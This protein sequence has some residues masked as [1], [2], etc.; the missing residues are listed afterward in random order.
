MV[1]T[2]EGY[3]RWAEALRLRTRSGARDRALMER[4]S[5]GSRL[6]LCLA[7]RLFFDRGTLL[8][9]D[10]LAASNPAQIPGL[11][12]DPRVE[13]YRAPAWRYP[14]VASAL[15]RGG[16]RFSDEVRAQTDAVGPWR[17]VSIRTYQREA[18]RA[19]NAAGRRGVVVL[20]TGSGKTRVAIA[21]MA[22]MGVPTLC[23][24][25]TRVLV[26][27]WC[28]EIGAHQG[29]PI[30]RYGDGK[31]DLAPVTVSTYAS[32]LRHMHELGNRFDLLVV[33]EAHHFGS[34]THDE[35]L[36]MC[37]APARLGLTATPV[38]EPG[39][40]RRVGDLI[41][42]TVYELAIG[43]LAGTFL[44]EFDV[45]TIGV[46]LSPD[47]RE[48]YDRRVAIYRAARVLFFRG[49]PDGTWGEFARAAARTA[50]GRAALSAWR[51]ARRLVSF[52]D[53]K[54]RAV[55]ELLARHRDA[56]VLVFVSDNVAA[57][58]IAAEH[59][60]MPLTCDIGRGERDE[61]LERFRKGELRALVSARVLNEG[62][63]VPAAE[64]AIVVGGS[65]GAREHVQRI[66]RLLRPVPG[67]RAVVYELVTRDTAEVIQV[68]KRRR[69]LAAR[70][71]AGLP[72]PG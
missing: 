6:A 5:P 41:G 39:A 70:R 14:E 53:E 59:L 40:A 32:A 19:W 47:E 2:G 3:R 60:I 18:L 55:G 69:G 12:W 38:L 28:D 66:G 27:Q 57:Y 20:P 37:T 23:L 1:V 8:L 10:T 54:R 72:S 26:D 7:V 52:C 45:V 61:A 64:V 43:D 11:L 35:A 46:D 33:D 15:A 4:A 29:H 34:G 68:E 31:R 25:P 9:R 71:A 17:E 16:V 62:L 36:E 49:D 21:A 50:D 13:A 44:A 24:V 63:D 65:L 42:P 22:R 48:R 58:A 56:R 67:K 51:E 30:G